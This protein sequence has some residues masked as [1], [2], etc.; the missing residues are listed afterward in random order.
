MAENG[1]H[2]GLEGGPE[3][4]LVEAQEALG[5]WGETVVMSDREHEATGEGVA[6]EEGNSGHGEAV[7]C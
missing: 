6:V 3:E 5:R 4:D 1:S 7:M 2:G